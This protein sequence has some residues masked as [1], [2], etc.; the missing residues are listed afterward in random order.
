MFVASVT[1]NL[2]Q[3][4][5]KPLVQLPAPVT[6]I[7]SQHA[8]VP[9]W[10]K[11]LNPFTKVLKTTRRREDRK[12]MMMGVGRSKMGVRSSGFATGGR[13]FEF[14]PSH[15]PRSFCRF[16]PVFSSFLH[17]KIFRQKNTRFLHISSGI[18]KKTLKKISQTEV[19]QDRSS[20][21]KEGGL[22]TRNSK[23]ET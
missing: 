11:S 13:K 14:S 6:F 8:S 17:Q 10:Q 21:I 1:T 23:R 19:N 18:R 22:S 2:S 4:I 16:F 20:R 3:R 12:A 5:A 7:L 15:D 9:L